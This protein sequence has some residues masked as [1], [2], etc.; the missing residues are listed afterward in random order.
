MSVRRSLVA[1]KT[2]PN[3]L[4][5]LGCSSEGSAENG[6]LRRK[7]LQRQ[8]P[9][10]TSTERGIFV[11]NTLDYIGAL[12]LYENVCLSKVTLSVVGIMLR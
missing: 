10:S 7:Y 3:C 12:G 8:L 11:K 2:R 4:V 5:R 6:I 9:G 1:S